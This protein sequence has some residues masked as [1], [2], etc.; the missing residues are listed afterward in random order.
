MND[1]QLFKALAEVDTSTVCN[2]LEIVMGRRSA[3]GFTAGRVVPID[4]GRS[5]RAST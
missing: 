4:P 5:A 2:A 1:L 3:S